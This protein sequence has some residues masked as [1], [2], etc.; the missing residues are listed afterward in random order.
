MAVVA[1]GAV[2]AYAD[3]NVNASCETSQTP[4]SSDRPANTTTATQTSLPSSFRVKQL[5]D[6]HDILGQGS[7]GIVYEAI[8]KT[9]GKA[10]A[11]KRI[12]RPS[13]PAAAFQRELGFMDHICR[14]RGG[15]AH[16]CLLYTSP[17]PRDGA[18]SRMPSSA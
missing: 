8:R 18:T 5:Y 12:H 14:I 6:I 1:F 16:I 9:D 15:H 10:V 2:A 7:F 17:S 13:T 4:P 3:T 11:L